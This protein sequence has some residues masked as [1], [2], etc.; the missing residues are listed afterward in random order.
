VYEPYVMPQIYIVD[1]GPVYSGPGI[2]TNPTV[3]VPRPMYYPQFEGY[4]YPAHLPA[5]SEPS[6]L[7]VRAQG[8]LPR[9]A[10]KRSQGR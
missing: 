3:V 2:W 10:I 5:Y 8:T 4:H 6:P 1:Q 7:R 9:R